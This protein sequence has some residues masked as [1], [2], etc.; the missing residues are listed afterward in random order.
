[1]P[2]WRSSPVSCASSSIRRRARFVW[3]RVWAARRN[4]T[5]RAAWVGR[6]AASGRDAPSGA[7]RPR[8]CDRLRGGPQRLCRG[9]CGK[10]PDH[11]EHLGCLRELVVFIVI[12]LPRSTT[13]HGLAQLRSYQAFR[14]G[15]R[16]APGEDA[17]GRVRASS[18][19]S[20]FSRP[21][22]VPRPDK[23]RL[24][25]ALVDLCADWSYGTHGATAQSRRGPRPARSSGFQRPPR[26]SRL[27]WRWHA[28]RF[29]RRWGEHGA[30]LR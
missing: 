29:P 18:D 28:A 20:V 6:C 27:G 1:M 23:P 24:V 19:E 5:M 13:P 16:C 3:T 15:R 30:C 4:R 8:R 17:D 26:G 7:C 2:T 25:T 21:E 9:A 11:T 14:S 22:G 12:G 10:A